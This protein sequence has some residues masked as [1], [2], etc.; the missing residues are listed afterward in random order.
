VNY[1]TRLVH[2]TKNVRMKTRGG[3]N[4]SISYHS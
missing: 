1:E 4:K 2:N 3:E